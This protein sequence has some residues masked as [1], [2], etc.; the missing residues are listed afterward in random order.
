MA[1][2][3]QVLSVPEDDLWQFELPDGRGIRKALAYLYP[4]LEDKSK[5]PLK[6]DIQSWDGWPAREPCLLFGGLAFGEAKY[7]DLWEKLPH[8][9]DMEVKRNIAITQPLL[10]VK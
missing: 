6:P 7:L 8:P 9:T 3:C 1:T 2:L 10:W 4:F 5:W